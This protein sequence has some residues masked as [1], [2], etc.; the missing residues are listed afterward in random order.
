MNCRFDQPLPPAVSTAVSRGH[1]RGF[2]LAEVLVV[3]GIIALLMGLLIP[4]LAMV[5]RQGAR[6]KS[7]AVLSSIATAI[8]AYRQDFGDYP[9][10]E[11]GGVDPLNNAEDR[12]ARLL[13]RALLGVAPADTDPTID[14]TDPRYLFRD[15]H[16]TPQSPFGFKDKRQ[17]V[18]RGGETAD[19]Y[20]GPVHEP[21][22]QA[23]R[24]DVRKTTDA[25]LLG[26]GYVYGPDAV[27]L[28][29]L[30]QKPI[31]YYPALAKQPA[32]SDTSVTFGDGG[33][34]IAKWNPGDAPK[35][36]FNASDNDS[37]TLLRDID[38]RDASADPDHRIRFFFRELLG[39][40]NQNGIIDG[41]E[42]AIT[43]PYLLIAVGTSG[44]YH[45]EPIVN[46]TPELPEQL[47]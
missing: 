15:G 39:D 17:T 22:L 26:Y 33:S 47:P 40:F 12:G 41:G 16:G 42:R 45:R 29:P 8:D 25:A 1:R 28:D 2:T 14:D 30:D 4:V 6:T 5:S 21:Y 31:L 13:A 11:V 7:Q 34:Y 20:P 32:I 37:A 19:F 44:T 43:Q 18:T 24:F 3:I 36:L 35:S 10:F 27:F 46:F 9:R 38:P 23:D